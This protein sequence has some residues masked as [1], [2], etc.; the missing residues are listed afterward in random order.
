[1]SLALICESFHRTTVLFWIFPQGYRCETT[2]HEQ[3]GESSPFE[4]LFSRKDI[5]NELRPAQIQA[6]VGELDGVFRESPAILLRQ[7]LSPLL[8]VILS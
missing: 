4:N 3:L 7:G 8:S 2:G 5:R 1:M 6:E